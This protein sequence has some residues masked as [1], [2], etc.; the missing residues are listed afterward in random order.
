[1]TLSFFPLVF[2]WVTHS[3]TQGSLLILHLKITSGGVWGTYGM[4]GFEYGVAA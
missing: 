2:L 1:M 3:D 4:L